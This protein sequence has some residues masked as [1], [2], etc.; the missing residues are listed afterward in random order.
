M[1]LVIKNG[2]VATGSGAAVIDVGIEDGQ[3]AQ[4]GG[5]MR[6]SQSIDAEGM[7]VLP[8]GVDP[9]VHLTPPRTG[10][11]ENSWADNFEIGT[12][13]AL[14]GGVTTV[15]NMSFPRK[16]ESMSEG[17]QRDIEDAQTQ[18]IADF[19]HHPVLLDPDQE[20]LEE[21]PDLA[22]QGHPSVKIFLSF[23]RFDRNVE[24]FLKAMRIAAEVGSV[25]LLHCEDAALMGCCGELVREAGLTSHRH[26]PETRPVVAE[27]IA[28]ERAIGFCE[29]SGAA[30]YIVHLSSQEALDVCRGGRARGLPLYVETRPI[31]L[32]LDRTRFDEPDGAKYAGAP[33][34]RQEQDQAALWAGVVDGAVSTV[35]T[36]HAPWTLEQKLDPSLGPAELRQGM[37]ELETSMPMLWA[38]G[39][40]QKRISLNRFVEVTSTNPAKLF[41]MYPQKG[42]IAPGSD[43]D[44]LILDPHETRIIDG[45]Q[46]HS[47]AGYSPYD[48]WEITGWP[49]FTI[50]IGEVVAE[51]VTVYDS[52]GRG[53]LVPR[54]PF[55][56]H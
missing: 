15:G 31:Y 43:A 33:P 51:G 30:T 55:E 23:K 36:D 2:T 10:P 48:G 6:A 56:R 21:I 38:L 9:H 37:A 8:G 12:R 32:H 3:I 46:M 49:R 52:H 28:T 34:L 40:A 1:D 47:A 24:G 19:F 5:T 45:S 14:A 35:A 20:A 41:G 54:E 4:L 39:V 29:I 44:L 42:C 16:G 17:L 11:G 25:V 26:Y 13:A 7:F 18:S 50:S 53:L 22:A 27:R